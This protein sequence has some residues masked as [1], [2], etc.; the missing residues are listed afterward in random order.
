MKLRKQVVFT[1]D[2]WAAIQDLTAQ[3]NDGFKLGHITYSDTINAMVLTSK[4]N[5]DTLRAKHT[6]VKRTLKSWA[7]KKEVD[8]NALI[9]DLN[10]LRSKSTKRTATSDGKEGA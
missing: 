5:V 2:A 7:S 6:D 4:A 10:E 9:K 3:A 8:L 1:H